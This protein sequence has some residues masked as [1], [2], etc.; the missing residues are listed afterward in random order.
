MT[1]SFMSFIKMLN[2]KGLRRLPCGTPHCTGDQL[3]HLLL[4]ITLCLRPVI[5]RV[6]KQ[7]P[8]RHR[9]L[10][11]QAVDYGIYSQK[12]WTDR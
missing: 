4:H 5:L 7:V 1:V 12:P 9:P 10:L 2:S 6:E 3:E 8:E 11:L